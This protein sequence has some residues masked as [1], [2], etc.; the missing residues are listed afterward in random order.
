MVGSDDHEHAVGAERHQPMNSGFEI[1]FMAA[2]IDQVDN[3]VALIDNVGPV[4]VLVEVESGR[5]DLLPLLVEAH[6]FVG[7]GAGPSRF[8]FVLIIDH[9]RPGAAPPIVQDVFG[10]H[11]DQGGLSR[12]HV[13][14][15]S[16]SYVLLLVHIWG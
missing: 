14:H 2:E 5:N 1:L 6:Y 9:Q 11:S 16:Y 12:V 8:Q 4:L 15:Q 10:E 7:D 13:S 3:L